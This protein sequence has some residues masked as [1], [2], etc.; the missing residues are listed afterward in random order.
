MFED[1]IGGKYPVIFPESFVHADVA[2]TM[3]RMKF[4]KLKP[5]NA[6]FL[7]NKNGKTY[8]TSESMGLGSKPS[9]GDYIL[10]GEAVRFMDEAQV[11]SLAA[12]YREKYG[13]EQ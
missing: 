5:V 10:L 13:V 6:G 1:D 4:G 9:D 8:G 3:R 11:V 12:L 2:Q 7:C